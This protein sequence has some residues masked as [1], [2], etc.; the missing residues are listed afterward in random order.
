MPKSQQLS[1]KYVYDEHMSCIKKKIMDKTICFIM[2][3]SPDVLGRPAINTLIAFYDDDE[4][5]KAVPL[6]DTCILK[7]YNCSCPE[8]GA[9]GIGQDMA[10]CYWNRLRL[11]CIHEEVI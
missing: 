3:E 7:A 2:D 8:Q 1:N 11:D 10:R 6:V 5:A 4:F 9:S